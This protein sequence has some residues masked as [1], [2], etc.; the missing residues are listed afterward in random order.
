[1]A[2]GTHEYEDDPRNAEI[3]IS[4]NGELLPRDKAV[5]SVFDSGFVLGDG[6]WEGL[7]VT[8]GG[9]AFLDEHL[10][11]LFEGAAAL[12]M[13]IGLDRAGLTARVMECLA[14]NDMRDGVH[15]RLMI[16]RGVKRT[17]YQ[18]PR[19][20]IGAPTIVVIPEY[21]NPKP[22]IA[23]EGVTL[24]T[25][26]VR[27]TGPAEQDQ[28]INSHSKLNC[29]LACIQAAKAGADEGLML[30]PAGFVATCNSTHF[31]IV[32]NGEVWTSTGDY[33][34]GGVTRGQVLKAAREAGI[35]AH[36]R[37]FSLTD[38]YGA[39]E[40]FITGTFAGLV[41]VRSVDGRTI[42]ALHP[43]RP[44]LLPRLTQLYRERIR[45]F[46]TPLS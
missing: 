28:K 41:P 4:V 44:K 21:K 18:D 42:G 29:I 25:V 32:R 16:T 6:I 9:I 46:A 30:D 12:D 15:V 10:D 34:L 26:H 14:A 2:T 20:T 7:R 24:F 38:V 5:V 35:A 11:R 17:P 1:M 40:A 33:C 37:R 43:E 22:E 8:D 31:F 3:L 39:D 36:E 45:S 13:D 19:M 27:R 23:S